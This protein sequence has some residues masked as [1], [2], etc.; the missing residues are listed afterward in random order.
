L[1]FDQP[2][3]VLLTCYRVLAAGAAADAGA[4]LEQAH[5]LLQ[6]MAG[7]IEDDAWRR[8]FL[9]AVP[10]HRALLALWQAKQATDA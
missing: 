1:G 2:I 10:A 8:T 7:T 9:E 4:V 3:R 6:Q 5:A